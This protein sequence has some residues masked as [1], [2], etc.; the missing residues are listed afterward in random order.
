MVTSHYPYLTFVFLTM[1]ALNCSF[2]EGSNM[3]LTLG[4]TA[5]IIGIQDACVIR[6]DLAIGVTILV[7][8]GRVFT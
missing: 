7:V 2:E 3:S 6:V 4:N 5:G 1:L 8:P